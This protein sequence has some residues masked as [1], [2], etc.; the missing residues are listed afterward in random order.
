MNTRKLVS[1]SKDEGTS[2][3]GLETRIDEQLKS[4][5]IDGGMKYEVEYI[6]V[7]HHTYNLILNY[8]MESL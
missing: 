5:G 7:T 4:K 1:H 6:P 8:Q 2:K 3:S